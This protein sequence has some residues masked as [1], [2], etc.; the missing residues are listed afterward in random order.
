MS[1]PEGAQPSVVSWFTSFVEARDRGDHALA[2]ACL[3]RLDGLGIRVAPIASKA[4]ARR[5]GRR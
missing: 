3:R 4:A 1:P 5:E 2:T